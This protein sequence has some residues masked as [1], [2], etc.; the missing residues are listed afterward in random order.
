MG[1]PRGIESRNKRLGR[2]DGDIL[3]AESLNLL[4]R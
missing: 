2:L 1:T 3:D 4:G